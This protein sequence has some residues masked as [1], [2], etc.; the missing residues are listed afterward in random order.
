MP[1]PEPFEYLIQ[2]MNIGFPGTYPEGTVA[3]SGEKQKM[4]DVRL[5][6]PEAEALRQSLLNMT[7]HHI[8]GLYS[9]ALNAHSGAWSN[10]WFYDLPNAQADFEHW[11]K[12]DYWKLDEA[13]ALSF[14]KNPHRV[15]WGKLQE[16]RELSPLAR[17]FEKRRE[18]VYRSKT[19]KQLSDPV[20]PGKFII[21]ALEKGFK[22]PAEL[23]KNVEKF[24]NILDWKQ[25]YDKLNATYAQ[26]NQLFD[27]QKEL[28]AAEIARLE[29]SIKNLE[30][31]ANSITEKNLS[32]RERESLFKI[33]IGMAIIGYRY[34]P[35]ADKTPTA[36]EIEEDLAK[37]GL[38]LN[39]DTIR[40]WLR[41]AAEVLPSENLNKIEN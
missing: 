41:A 39:E 36:A 22:M 29:A 10:G 33:I 26:L 15:V 35:K 11:A 6:H 23:R 30:E 25:A 31:K 3:T 40:K 4:L 32:V 13:L 28:H 17:E 20:L 9:S 5:S 8:Q 38:S 12:M 14:G 24:G 18:I 34:D 21:W 16:F 1:E 27:K 2:L 37:L 19:I 7:F